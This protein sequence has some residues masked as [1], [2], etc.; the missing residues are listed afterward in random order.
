MQVVYKIFPLLLIGFMTTACNTTDTSHLATQ[1]LF[2]DLNVIARALGRDDEINKKL[3][4]ARLNLNSQLKEIGT[5]LETQLQDKKSEIEASG[6]DQTETSEA[7]QKLALQAQIQLKQ[8]QQL[9]EQKATLFRS[10]LLNAFRQE[11]K[12]VAQQIAKK[13]GALT[14]I[15]ATPE[16]IWYDSRIDITDEVIGVMRSQST[17]PTDDTADTTTPQE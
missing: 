10:Q 16:Y 14:V 8:S 17:S 2:V 6:K 12:T 9:A 4:E 15:T 5:S 13:R 3:E 11:V 1:P 7:L